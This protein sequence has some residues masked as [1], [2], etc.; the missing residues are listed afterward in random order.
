MLVV[1]AYIY[2][3]VFILPLTLKDRLYRYT[4]LVGV[5][6][7]HTLY[8]LFSYLLFS[9]VVTE[10]NTATLIPLKIMDIILW[11]LRFFCLWCFSILLSFTWAEVFKKLILLG[12]DGAS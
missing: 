12:V 1:N 2:L 4:I 8:I 11:L 9:I 6:F 3:N 7:S 10:K 5:H